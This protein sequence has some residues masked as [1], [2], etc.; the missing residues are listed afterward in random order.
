MDATIA[1]RPDGSPTGSQF[2]TEVERLHWDPLDDLERERFYVEQLV[3][4]NVPAFM[5]RFV[6]VQVGQLTLYV[7]PDYLSVG[8]DEDYVR[9]PMNPHSAQR[10]LDAWGC[11]L[12][13]RML[14]DATYRASAVKI[15]FHAMTPPRYPYTTDMMTTRRYAVHQQMI[16]DDLSK[17]GDGVHPPGQLW[18]G[19]KKD[20]V[21][22]PW[23]ELPQVQ[24]HKVGV[25]GAYT[26]GGQPIHNFQTHSHPDNYKDY[27]HGVRA[28]YGI[29]YAMD[30]TPLQVVDVLRGANWSWLERRGRYA[31]A[32]YPV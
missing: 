32:R 7:A 9:V 5:R 12:P 22:D 8:T 18:A 13:T 1:D 24:Y 21:L 29:C 2:I 14:V 11:T 25:Y 15:P 20:L 30:G 19:H 10:I 4:G 26:P 17:L 28:V 6:A 23:L 3:G 27:S 16:A 31:A